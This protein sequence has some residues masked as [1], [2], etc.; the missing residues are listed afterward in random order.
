MMV[1]DRDYG[2]KS[3][4]VKCS[5]YRDEGKLNNDYPFDTEHLG[6]TAAVV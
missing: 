4:Q 3:L 2:H 6:D 1:I 5:S